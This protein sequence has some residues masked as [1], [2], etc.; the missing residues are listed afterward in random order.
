MVKT[1]AP[2]NLDRIRNG[3]RTNED[4]MV[5]L[6]AAMRG[7]NFSELEDAHRATSAP[8]DV[9][10]L[11]A[12]AEVPALADVPDVIR[13]LLRGP[14][15]AELLAVAA[16]LDAEYN[17]SRYIVFVTPIGDVRCRINWSSCGP[18][19]LKREGMLFVKLRSDD[20]VFAP[21][22]GAAFDIRFEGYAGLAHVTCL[23]DP[24]RLYPGVD[25]L[26]FMIH[27]HAV[28]KTGQLKDGAPSSVSGDSSDD[29]RDGEPVVRGEVPARL[30]KSA[31]ATLANESIA[32]RKDWDTFRK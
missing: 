21:K 12:L 30:S 17:E 1:S 20:M 32:G 9:G 18:D 26:C 28:E 24:Q 3:P 4:E 10:E 23:A 13:K 16:L 14:A 31:A 5:E 2:K 27:N 19:D 8:E 15:K 25:L 7:G 29:V 6:L 22:P 11:P